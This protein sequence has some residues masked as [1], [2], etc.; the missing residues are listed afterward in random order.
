MPMKLL[1]ETEMAI[2]VVFD[3]PVGPIYNHDYPRR[4][5]RGVL[6]PQVHLQVVQRSIFFRSK[7]QIFTLKG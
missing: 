4:V 5:G 1:A 2:F 6:R 3:A 7:K